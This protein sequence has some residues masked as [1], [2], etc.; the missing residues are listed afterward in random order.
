M[1]V[2]ASYDYSQSLVGATYV[3]FLTND[4]GKAWKPMYSYRLD[5]PWE[6]DCQNLNSLNDRLAW[7]WIGRG[8]FFVTH[9]G[10][11]TWSKWTPA[12]TWPNSERD[13]RDGV[14]IQGITFESVEIGYMKLRPVCEISELYSDDGGI[15]W[16]ESTR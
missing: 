12:E 9:D 6:P 13:C 10:G 8:L 15:T 2:A 5:E 11:E 7:T 14:E 3:F 4:G 16:R 1:R